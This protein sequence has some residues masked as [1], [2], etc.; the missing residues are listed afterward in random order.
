MG[1]PQCSSDLL[2][3]RAL[4]RS[5]GRFMTNAERPDSD[6]ASVESYQQEFKITTK[7]GLDETANSAAHRIRTDC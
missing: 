6:S 2:N 3:T 7:T 4:E 1:L 5:S